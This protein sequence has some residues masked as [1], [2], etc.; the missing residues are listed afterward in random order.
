MSLCRACEAQRVQIVFIPISGGSFLRA[1]KHLESG[2]V[3]L[4]VVLFTFSVSQAQTPATKTTKT[5]PATNKTWT[6]PRTPWGDPDLQGI[7]NNATST[8]LQRPSQFD[9][10]ILNEEEAETLQEQL[11]QS[12]NSD[13][14]PA[15]GVGTYNDLWFDAQ[16]KELTGDKRTSLI[17]DP[18]DGRIPPRL[19]MT[20]EQKK[21]NDA[22]VAGA[23]RYNAGLPDSYLDMAPPMRCVIRTDRPPYLGI[24]Y[25]NTE[26]IF[27]APGYVVIASEMV[28]SA[29]LISLDG[30]P[31]LG[32]D[33]SQ[34][35]GDARGHWEGDTLVV[36]S[37][38]FRQE[39]TY[40]YSQGGGD[41]LGANPATYHITERF[42][43]VDA[44]TLKYEF[45]V[46]DPQ[47]WA[48][49]W[50][51]MVPWKLMG[52]DNQLYEY[53]C[54]EDNYDIMHYLGGA[55]TREKAAQ[56]KNK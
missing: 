43:R 3:L 33:L 47:T 1:L 32:K 37:T 11:R 39:G 16:R 36:D 26:Q 15:D 49:P 27:Q 52:A 14:P 5:T 53:A 13:N 48:K 56:T 34:W 45:T 22:I 28:H 6:P 50:S 46:S 54:H 10:P 30:R 24:I 20:P 31:H 8:P 18:P 25:N 7:Y 55:R 21:Q 38:N 42:T 23:Q 19:Q 9:K 40:G 4:I 17:V 12:I 44:K 41:Q 51:A 29:R 35:L 2:A